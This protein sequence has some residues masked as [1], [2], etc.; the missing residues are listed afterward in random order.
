MDVFGMIVVAIITGTGGGTLRSLFLGD[1]PP[2]FIDPAYLII[3]GAATAFI[4]F[5]QS[6]WERFTRIVSFF[7]ALGLGVFVCIG[8]RIAQNH[9]LDWWAALA[10][11]VITAT[12]G[13]VLRDIVR[14][15]IPLIFRKEI[16][17]TACLLGGLVLLGLDALSVPASISITITAILTAAIRIIAVRYAINRS[18]G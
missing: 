11:G 10:M 17:A 8:I 1:V 6:F 3:A 14:N 16:Y 15:E 13:G 18:E 2:V 4:A 9:D 7:D 12:F 5:C